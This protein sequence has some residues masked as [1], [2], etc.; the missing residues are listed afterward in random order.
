[1]YFVLF[2]YIVYKGAYRRIEFNR[3]RFH[4]T[5]ILSGFY[6]ERGG[7]NGK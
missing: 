3:V 4:F 1:M 5:P 7:K 2:E 6:N